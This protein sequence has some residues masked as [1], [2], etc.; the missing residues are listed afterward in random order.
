VVAAQW[1][2]PGFYAGVREHLRSIPA[3][4]AEMHEAEPIQE[5]PVTVLT[6]GKAAPLTEDD[7]RRI[8]KHVRQVIAPASAHW[9]HLDEPHLV[10][11]S[12]LE[13]LEPARAECLVAGLQP[14]SAF[15]LAPSGSPAR[16]MNFAAEL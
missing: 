16:T 1:S 10:V 15:D 12:I 8:G 6:P 11:A 4:V 3:T 7:L 2:R 5:I 13:M 14:A 9:I